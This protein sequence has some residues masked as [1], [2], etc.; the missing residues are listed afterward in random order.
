[1]TRFLF[2]IGLGLLTVA[3]R[4]EINPEYFQKLCFAVQMIQGVAPDGRMFTG[5]GVLVAPGRAIT[6]CHVVRESSRIVFGRGGV[7]AQG[8][9]MA[10]DTTRDVCVVN[11]SEAQGAISP[12]RSSATL[13]VGETVY[14]VGFS[15][16]YRASIS[17]GQ[18]VA[19]HPYAGGRVIQ[20][21]A[22]F[23]RGAS[24]GGLFDDSGHLVGIL[25][26]YRPGQN[27]D[28]FF[29]LPVDWIEEVVR[30][31]FEPLAPLRG[32]SPFWAAAEDA[33]P[34]FLKTGR[35]AAQ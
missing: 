12:T 1:M 4:A 34:A 6:N 14:A 32:G 24:G 30:S 33:L 2:S 20:V 18:I 16:G 10:H 17:E 11:A 19:L 9:T 27:G 21:N 5:S 23:G 13:H 28:L 15:G 31:G 25:T 22:P 8:E 7:G 29:A 26:F 35:T 3:A